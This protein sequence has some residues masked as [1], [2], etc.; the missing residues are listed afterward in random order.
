MDQELKNPPWSSK[1]RRS[2][3][4]TASCQIPASSRPFH[5]AASW[6]WGGASAP[7]TPGDNGALDHWK[8]SVEHLLPKLPRERLPSR[9]HCSLALLR[10]PPL[11]FD[12]TA[13]WQSATP[14]PIRLPPTLLCR[15]ESWSLSESQ[16]WVG[17]RVGQVNDWAMP[18]NCPHWVAP[19]LIFGAPAPSGRETHFLPL[20]SLALLFCSRT[21]PSWRCC[22]FAVLLIFSVSPKGGT[23]W[24]YMPGLQLA[25]FC[26]CS[27]MMHLFTHSS[28]LWRFVETLFWAKYFSRLW[29]CCCE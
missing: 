20:T 8:E 5:C 19:Y 11:T 12:L 29:R 26:M 2:R 22:N 1:L 25:P 4:F 23:S 17:G 14:C 6:E 10:L 9:I 21:H 24:I 18:G 15:W 3:L 7:L 27:R 28:T 13:W 16:D